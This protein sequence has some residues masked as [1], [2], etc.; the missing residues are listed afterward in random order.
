MGLLVGPRRSRL[1]VTGGFPPY[2]TLALML[3][4]GDSPQDVAAPG[5]APLHGFQPTTIGPMVAT[6]PFVCSENV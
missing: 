5:L 2:M 4:A 3:R 1:D 6:S